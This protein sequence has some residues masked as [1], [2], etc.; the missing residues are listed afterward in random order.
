MIPFAIACVLFA[1]V[2]WALSRTGTRTE[3]AQQARIGDWL[4][5]RVARDDDDTGGTA[6]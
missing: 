6:A 5:R 1:A 4:A 2:A 3:E